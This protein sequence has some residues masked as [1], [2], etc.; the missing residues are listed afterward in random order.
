MEKKGLISPKQPSESWAEGYLQPSLIASKPYSIDLVPD[1]DVKLDQNESPWD[2]PESLKRKILADV[3]KQSWNRYPSP[4]CE[5]VTDLLAQYIGVPSA[6]IVTGPGSNHLITLL[7]DTFAHK[8]PG[9]VVIARPSFALF[10]MHCRYTGVEYEPWNLTE[11][12]EYDISALDGLPKHSFVVFASPNNPTGTSLGHDKLKQLLEAHPESLFLA[13]E[14]YYE[15]SSESCADLLES[16]SNL[17]IV[18]TLS[19]TMGSAGVR[20]GYVLGAPYWVSQIAKLRLPYL[21]NH[22]TVS[23]AKVILSDPEMKDFINRN[24]EN[25]IGERNRLYN[26]LSAA[27]ASNTFQVFN[28]KANFILLRCPDEQASDRIYKGLVN[29][30]VL[31]RDV[32]KGPGLAGCLRISIGRSEE[33][34]RVLNSLKNLLLS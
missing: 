27:T 29:D 9:K 2:W 21:L 15:F 25:A 26:E 19:K 17:I 4:Y 3:E 8:L 16:Y 1:V 22:F 13:D 28:S 12:F 10:E 34:N 32:S 20:L 33:N 14:A 6:S 7:F 11:D 5:E 30:G 18:R 23:A 24:I 31:I